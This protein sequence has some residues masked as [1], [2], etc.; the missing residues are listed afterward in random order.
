MGEVYRADD[1]ELGQTVALKLLPQE[2]ADNN[3]ALR[4]LRN[5]VRVA[6][7]VA[8]PNVCRVYDLG[9]V[10][11][12]YFLS[13]EYVDGEDL[14]GLLRRI[15]RLPR[16]KG[17]EIARQLCAGL[18]AA[19][20]AGILH[21][22][23][24]P[25]NIIVDGRG[26][27]RIMDFGLA[28]FAEEFRK[29]TPPAGTL[30]Y[31][32]PEQ[33]AGDGVTKQSDIYSLGLVLY[34]LF[35]GRRVHETDSVE[36]LHELHRS[37]PPAS[38][39]SLVDGL[40]PAIERAVLRCLEPDPADRPSSVH[41]VSGALPGGDPL[42]AALAAGET[43]SPE[44]VAAAGRRGGL[45]PA[46]GIAWLAVVV[47]GIAIG[48]ALNDRTALHRLVPVAKSPVVMAD[49]A[50]EIL[51]RLGYGDELEDSAYWFGYNRATLRRIRSTEAAKDRWDGL[52]STQPS[53]MRFAY[54]G[55][56]Q[57]MTPYDR[58]SGKV[59]WTDPPMDTHGM[60]R[61]VLDNR[62][63]LMR[64]EVVSA[65]RD[66]A[67]D[68]LPT[69]DWGLLFEM[70]ELN[71]A[72]FREVT[73]RWNPQFSRDE[74]I[75]WVGTYPGQPEDTIRVEAGAHHG[76]PVYFRIFAAD[77]ELLTGVSASH[78]SGV[79]DATDVLAT[80]GEALQL[81]L[82]LVLL[83][84]TVL[85]ARRNLRLGRG[86]RRGAWRFGGLT[87]AL[88]ILSWALGAH[89]SP[90]WETEM[91]MLLGGLAEALFLAAWFGLAYLAA[92]PY[93]RRYWPHMLISWT[94]L[95]AGR[96]RDPRVG[97]DFLVG[98]A[99]GT[100][101]FVLAKFGSLL[102]TW[103]GWP[104]S[105]LDTE[106]ISVLV[107]GRTALARLVSPDFMSIALIT[108]FLVPLLWLLRRKTLVLV[109]A[110]VILVLSGYAS[111]GQDAASASVVI[112]F[113]TRCL[114]IAAFLFL[115]A[116]IGLLAILVAVLYQNRLSGFPVTL[117]TS[118]WYWSNSLILFIVLAGLALLAFRF[119]TTDPLAARGRSAP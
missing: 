11:G 24:K 46:W 8:H 1:L 29:G 3:M 80:I 35:T 4:L 43:P 28:G 45:K 59:D 38:L 32:A 78:G 2:L 36:R 47:L 66:V 107:G 110:F 31:M 89:H 65:P 85:I 98:A 102:P 37:G 23:L 44:M 25:A 73:P 71:I 101:V 67:P 41:M 92:E 70:A 114:L 94:R 13:M 51:E 42:T 93:L 108:V 86:D 91:V 49:K 96:Y 90:R 77:D 105:N 119:A 88:G 61:I 82:L 104:I 106:A 10:D 79:S 99:W 118:A 54:R 56:A 113:V 16:E 53:P 55:S 62:E 14:A 7:Q 75:A 6:R 58:S 60:S 22:D 57:H 21:R 12:Q 34:E 84:G 112:L 33:L 30:V 52:A 109:V 100:G 64:F 76:R 116:R 81:I 18:A 50:E 68:S 26:R 19:H 97:Q 39:S 15:G 48:A 95:T 20:D 17:I 63:R 111:I 87:L 103:F 27:V 117:D 72:T 74:R 9:E 83:L 69:A 5:E 115:L 40:D